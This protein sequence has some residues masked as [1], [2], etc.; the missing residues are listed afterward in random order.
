[1][2]NTTKKSTQ[3]TQHSSFSNTADSTHQLFNRESDGNGSDKGDIQNVCCMCASR[4]S[5]GKHCICGNVSRARVY[6]T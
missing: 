4:N 6:L 3:P 2:Y 1:M 5:A